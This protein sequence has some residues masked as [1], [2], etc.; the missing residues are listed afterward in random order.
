[1]NSVCSCEALYEGELCE[2]L[3]K[4]GVLM[5][6]LKKKAKS[7]AGTFKD[8]GHL[9]ALEDSKVLEEASKEAASLLSTDSSSN[10][11]SQ[12][13]KTNATQDASKSSSI[14]S[15]E[16]STNASSNASSNA[17][18]EVKAPL[19]ASWLGPESW[20]QPL[21][22]QQSLKVRLEVPPISQPEVMT[23]AASEASTN[24]DAAVWHQAV[25]PQAGVSKVLRSTEVADKRRS[26]LT[27][28]STGSHREQ[29]RQPTS[30]HEHHE[31]WAERPS[32]DAAAAQAGKKPEDDIEALLEDI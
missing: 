31:H 21:S 4:F 5:K 2:R 6:S 18:Q 1:M 15:T 25:L 22:K 32:E 14:L 28:L 9:L 27:L 26:I 30:V 23:A 16:I 19:T 7:D 24:P 10:A 8:T 3:S 13:A 17:S 11:T 12:Q 29:Q 20:I